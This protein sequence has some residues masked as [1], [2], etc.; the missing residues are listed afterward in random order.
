MLDKEMFQLLKDVSV[1]MNTCTIMN[2]TLVWDI[3][4]NRDNTSC[5]DIDPDTLYE[6]PYAEEQIA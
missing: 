4:G 2:D 1:F 3:Q 5:L 6:L